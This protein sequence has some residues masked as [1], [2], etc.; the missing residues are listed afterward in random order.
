VFRLFG[1]PKL[2]HPTFGPI[3]FFKYGAW[4][5][6]SCYFPP[7]DRIIHVSLTAGREGPSEAQTA[8]FSNLVDNYDSLK[9]TIAKYLQ[10]ECDIDLDGIWDYL[11]LEFIQIT[12]HLQGVPQH[13]QA[14]FA[15]R[16]D[17]HE[18]TVEFRDFEPQT[19][20]VDG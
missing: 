16:D 17:D 8:F 2:E 4:R 15:P 11:T 10:A 5:G 9:P 1:K 18:I 7:V 3:R 19:V 14:G 6:D 13:W 12:N 20:F